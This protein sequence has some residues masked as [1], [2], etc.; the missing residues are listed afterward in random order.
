MTPGVADRQLFGDHG[1][2]CSGQQYHTRAGRDRPD[3]SLAGA[4]PESQP[5]AVP[6]LQPH[7]P[8]GA[9]CPVALTQPGREDPSLVVILFALYSTI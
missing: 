1:A 4:Q 6:A 3:P 8:E 7:Q 2:D 9:E 5:G